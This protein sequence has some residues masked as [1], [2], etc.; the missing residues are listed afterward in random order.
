MK[1]TPTCRYGHGELLRED[2]ISPEAVESS[3]KYS[4]G[5]MGILEQLYR[6]AQGESGGD[7]PFHVSR[8][9]S[10]HVFTLRL[11]KCSTCGYLELFDEEVMNGGA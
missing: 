11:Y 6:P 4:W 5:L 8:G 9:H 3:K 7:S 2:V 1:I 10:G